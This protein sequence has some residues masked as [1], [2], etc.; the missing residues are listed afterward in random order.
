MVPSVR[1]LVFFCQG[2]H[3]LAHSNF[4]DVLCVSFVHLIFIPIQRSTNEKP[5]RALR[6][7]VCGRLGGGNIFENIYFRRRLLSQLQEKLYIV[8]E[9]ITWLV[10]YSVLDANKSERRVKP[11]HLAP[12][13]LQVC[14]WKYYQHWQTCKRKGASLSKD[15]NVGDSP[16]SDFIITAPPTE[17]CLACASYSSTEGG[18]GSVSRRRIHKSNNLRC[19][20]K[21]K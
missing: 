15:Y 8:S 1:L 13:R 7:G 20:N 4:C 11:S 3:E 5:T 18:T 17:D 9:N 19:I 6:R 14:R 10:R 12:T 21:D 2:K 16:T